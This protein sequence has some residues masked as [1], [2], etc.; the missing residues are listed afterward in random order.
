M[1]RWTFH[2]FFF[3]NGVVYGLVYLTVNYN[4]RSRLSCLTLGGLEKLLFE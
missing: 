2:F 4:T 3:C 1:I